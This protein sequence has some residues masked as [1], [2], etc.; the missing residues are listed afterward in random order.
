MNDEYQTYVE[1]L[2]DTFPT[3]SIADLFNE[4]KIRNTKI[5]KGTLNDDPN[6]Y[7]YLYEAQL[8]HNE[9]SSKERESDKVVFYEDLRLRRINYELK[10]SG[11]NK[12]LR[13]PLLKNQEKIKVLKHKLTLVCKLRKIELDEKLFREDFYT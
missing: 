2:K 7:H 13:T 12:V 11:L 9:I 3:L 1:H 8:A 5:I 4:I 10:V 6:L